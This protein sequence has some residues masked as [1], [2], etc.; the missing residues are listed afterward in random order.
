MDSNEF[1]KF[2]EDNDAIRM[3][4]YIVMSYV[5]VTGHECWGAFLWTEID[6]EIYIN[7]QPSYSSRGDN[8]KDRCILYAKGKI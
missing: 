3:N 8:A 1:R 7:N 4:D 6:G 5:A 2:I